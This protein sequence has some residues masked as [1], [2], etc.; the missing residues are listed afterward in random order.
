VRVLLIEDE[1]QVG[2][3]IR[4][5]LEVLNYQVEWA[6]TGEAALELLRQSS[7]DIVLQDYI[8]PDIGGNTL[9]EEVRKLHSGALAVVTGKLDLVIPNTTVISKPCMFDEFVTT[10]KELASEI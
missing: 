6:T 1:M 3:I 9:L 7:Y 10:I 8:L 2:K 4:Q 5:F